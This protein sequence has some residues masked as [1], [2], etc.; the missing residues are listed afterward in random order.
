[1]YVAAPQHIALYLTS[2]FN[3]TYLHK[4]IEKTYS[5]TL[6][7]IYLVVCVPSG[8]FATTDQGNMRGTSVLRF[9]EMDTSSGVDTETAKALYQKGKS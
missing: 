6:V 3:M 8:S 2:H 7:L 4:K 1:V 5:F 9:S